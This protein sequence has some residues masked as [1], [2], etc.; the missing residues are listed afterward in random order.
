GWRMVG[1]AAGLQFLQA[2]LLHQAFGA[3]V[4]VLSTERGWSKTAL[5]GAAALQSMETALLG[6]VL[7][8]FIDRFGA[9]GMIRLGVLVFG[10]GF[11]LLSSIDTIAGFYAAV[12]VI[13]IGSA[14]C[15]YFPLSV[16]IIHWFERFRARALSSIGFGLAV[17][18]VAVPAVAW[19]M[20]AYGW[21]A[22]AFG[23]GV[24]AIAVGFP[25]SL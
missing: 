25:L 1:A 21:R 6:P 18:G 24:V 12:I 16:A 8:W 15:G 14:M 2:A 23:A 22:T 10:A 9:Q 11:M 4:A 5:S 17:G 20:Q 19:S 13:A 3:Y 7:G